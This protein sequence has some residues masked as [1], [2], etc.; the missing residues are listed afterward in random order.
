[1]KHGPESTYAWKGVPCGFSR[2]TRQ[3]GA[4]L[5]HFKPT[6]QTPTTPN[7]RKTNPS[8]TQQSTPQVDRIILRLRTIFPWLIGVKYGNFAPKFL[9]YVLPAVPKN[10]CKFAA[11]HKDDPD[12]LCVNFNSVRQSIIN[13]NWSGVPPAP[14]QLFHYTTSPNEFLCYKHPL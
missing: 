7:R 9:L 4:S 13:K 11:T 1:M 5:I 12:T 6:L 3:K 10:Q 14:P 2:C 8:S